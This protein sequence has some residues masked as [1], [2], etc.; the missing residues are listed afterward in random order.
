MNKNSAR[1]IALAALASSFAATQA[2]AE[3]STTAGNSLNSRLSSAVLN[4][5]SSALGAAK[6]V[7]PAVLRSD[8]DNDYWFGGAHQ[9]NHENEAAVSRHPQIVHESKFDV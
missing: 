2:A 6:T 5:R 9:H 3:A 4:H 7:A 1:M 8:S